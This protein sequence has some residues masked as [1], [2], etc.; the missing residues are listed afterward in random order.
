MVVYYGLDHKIVKNKLTVN[1]EQLSHD[2]VIKFPHF[3]Y[4]FSLLITEKEIN[5]TLCALL[6]RNLPVYANFILLV[7][8]LF[9]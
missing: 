9:K 6:N 2:T 1:I 7:A 3:E 4:Y 5:K 8:L